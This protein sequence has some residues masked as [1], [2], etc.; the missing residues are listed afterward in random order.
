M[1]RKKILEIVRKELYYAIESNPRITSANLQ[2]ICY[3]DKF[4]FLIDF[5]NAIEKEAIKNVKPELEKPFALFVGDKYYP[6]E[7]IEDLICQFKT[8][9]EAKQRAKQLM[10]RA[11]EWEQRWWQIADIRSL[12]IIKDGFIG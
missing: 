8:I 12:T 3:A 10:S 11:S 2:D 6:E 7:G 5:A 4:N 1:L 9:E